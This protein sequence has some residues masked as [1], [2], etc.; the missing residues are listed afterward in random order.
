MNSSDDYFICPHCGAEVKSTSTICKGC[1]SED[2]TGWSEE[3]DPFV[4]EAP[5]S[6]DYDETL[7]NE[8]GIEEGKYYQIGCA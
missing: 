3:A 8:F 2:V 6:F 4:T 1:G 7:E 5:E